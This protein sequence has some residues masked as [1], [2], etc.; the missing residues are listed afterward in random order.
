[1]CHFNP[2]CFYIFRRSWS[3]TLPRL[4]WQMKSQDSEPWSRRRKTKTSKSPLDPAR[5][6]HFLHTLAPFSQA[7]DAAV[8]APKRLISVCKANPKTPAGSWLVKGVICWKPNH[9]LWA[10]QTWD[11]L[12]HFKVHTVLPVPLEAKLSLSVSLF[13]KVLHC[14][15]YC[16]SENSI[17][18]IVFLIF[19]FAR[20]FLFNIYL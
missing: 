15:G 12:Q 5:S 14:K 2:F 10:T 11:W 1:M 17:L 9:E 8:R 3:L 20:V 13:L 19:L 16:Q 18:F 6:A 7:P 4:C